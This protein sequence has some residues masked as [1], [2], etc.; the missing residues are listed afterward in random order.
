MPI[1]SATRLPR[2][3]SKLLAHLPASCEHPPVQFRGVTDAMA[4][5]T[6]ESEA[7]FI[8]AVRARLG[9][10]LDADLMDR[11]A[12]SI[13]E[14]E[15]DWR[16]TPQRPGETAL[17]LRI[18]RFFIRDDDLP[19]IEAIGASA[20]ALVALDPDPRKAIA[21]LIPV[22]TTLAS[23]AWNLW[24]KGVL[25]SR[26]DMA[27]LGLLRALDGATPETLHAKAVAAGQEIGDVAAI[28]RR[29]NRLSEVETRDGSELKLTK[30]AD[31]L[32]MAVPL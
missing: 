13:A 32:W 23:A 22:L 9:P 26:E 27:L 8:D 5:A 3:P 16:A 7:D 12:A 18:G 10:A 4:T 14:G 28:T 15:R 31:D 20:S 29:L 11:L 24:R 2:A 1:R 30:Q 19:V 21:G 17:N 6:F 25:L